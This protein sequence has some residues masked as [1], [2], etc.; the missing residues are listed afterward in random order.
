MFRIWPRQKGFPLRLGDIGMVAGDTSRSRAYVQALARNGL[1]PNYVLVLESAADIALPGQLDKAHSRHESA[2]ADETDECWS[3]AHFDATRP[4]KLLLD[5][6]AIPYDTVASK[7]I[8]DSSVVDAIR[9]STESV[10]IYSGFGGAL[11]RKEVLSAGKRFLH[12][13][14]GYLPT[15]REALQITTA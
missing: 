12:V 7:D 2:S 8:N 10:F 13:H 1:L 6:L 14:G 15:T 5:E 9:R 3:E 4:L 11:L